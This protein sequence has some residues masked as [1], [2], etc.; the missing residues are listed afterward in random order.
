MVFFIQGEEAAGNVEQSR[1]FPEDRSRGESGPDFHENGFNQEWRETTFEESGLNWTI[2][3]PSELIAE[4][5]R[6]RFVHGEDLVI[7]AYSRISRYHLSTFR[8][9]HLEADKYPRKKVFLRY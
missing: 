1:A 8:L 4:N 7:D 5:E 6:P 2:V 9:D 3:K